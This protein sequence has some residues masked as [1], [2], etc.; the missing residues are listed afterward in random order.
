MLGVAGPFRETKQKPEPA[1]RRT[2]KLDED[3]SPLPPFALALSDELALPPLQHN[4]T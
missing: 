4:D 2:V 1:G 3:A